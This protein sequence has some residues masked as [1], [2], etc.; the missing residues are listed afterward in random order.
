M[1]RSKQQWPYCAAGDVTK[2]AALDNTPNA[3][4]SPISEEVAPPR[5]PFPA[6]GTGDCARYIAARTD[7]MN[8]DELDPEATFVL[9]ETA[10]TRTSSIEQLAEYA[11]RGRANRET[12]TDAD[13]HEDDD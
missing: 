1:M 11:L 4:D 7:A 13:A 10:I 12:E 9:E 6:F 2:A 5:P 3:G 8:K